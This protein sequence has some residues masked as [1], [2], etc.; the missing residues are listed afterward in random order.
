MRAAADIKQ[1][2]AVVVSDLHLS[3]NVPLF[4]RL[5]ENE[6]LQ[7]VANTCD[8]IA[9][10][11]QAYGRVPVL[12]AGDI[13][14]T[15]NPRP[16]VVNLALRFLPEMFVV[17]GNHDAENHDTSNES[18]STSTAL[19]VLLNAGRV[20]LLSGRKSPIM[21][22]ID[23]HP[24]YNRACIYGLSWDEN[25][26][27]ASARK[28]ATSFNILVMHRYVWTQQSNHGPRTMKPGSGAS[29]L[30]HRYKK[31]NQYMHAI[32]TGDN[33][34]PFV[35]EHDDQ[36]LVNCGAYMRRSITECQYM[37][38]CWL[39]GFDK[40]FHFCV[41]PIESRVNSETK[42]RASAVRHEPSGVK[43]DRVLDEFVDD[44]KSAIDVSSGDLAG[45]QR[46]AIEHVRSIGRMLTRKYGS[47][48]SDI[49]QHLLRAL[50]NES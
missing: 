30:L 36:V 26:L 24:L 16:L 29:D 2:I 28:T 8:E 40:H 37:C 27:E 39:I 17:A 31:R 19:G 42:D 6:W 4:Q 33:H 48:A 12:C 1:P 9:Q 13:F 18:L 38:Q 49:T 14:D 47:P 11:R 10:V 34:I 15:Y 35:F 50:T 20:E 3:A 21:L 5:T 7:K 32:F 41:A 22:A 45:M 44:L 43:P 25:E 46:A 23:D